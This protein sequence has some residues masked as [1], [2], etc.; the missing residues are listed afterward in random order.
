MDEARLVKEVHVLVARLQSEVYAARE[1]VATLRDCLN[2]CGI[3]SHERFLARLHFRRFEAALRLQPCRCNVALE[4]V[5]EILGG[6]VACAESAGWSAVDALH[7][8]SKGV[9]RALDNALP[10]PTAAFHVAVNGDLWYPVVGTCERLP[11][12]MHFI[13]QHCGMTNLFGKLYVCGGMGYADDLDDPAPE[14][15]LDSVERFDSGAG[16]WTELPPMAV[17]R[18]DAAVAVVSRKIYVCGGRSDTSNI[19]SS[20]ERFDP[21]T[22]AWSW[23]PPMSARR[24]APGATALLGK[25]YVCGGLCD[26]HVPLCSME[27]FD[28]VTCAWTQLPSMSVERY[29]AVATA[30]LGALYISGGYRSIGETQN[31]VECFDPI[32]GEW[33]QLPPMPVMRGTRFGVSAIEALHGKIYVLD[34]LN[35]MELSFDLSTHVWEHVPMS[36]A[37]HDGF[38]ES[39]KSRTDSAQ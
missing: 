32:T 36:L 12:G 6:S 30:L 39:R 4:T 16:L 10:I 27:C 5:L 3:L 17:S 28:P 34:Q 33:A 13:R 1:D 18:V 25:L 31:S 19:L 20:V 14:E 22:G 29:P 37:W 21:G 35:Y 7:S 11:A 24:S 38:C 8:T 15:W 2:I 26:P 9:A 23:V